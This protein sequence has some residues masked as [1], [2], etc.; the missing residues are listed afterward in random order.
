MDTEK[1]IRELR[2]VAIKPSAI[3]VLF[4]LSNDT[5]Y[6]VPFLSCR[7]KGDCGSNHT[8]IQRRY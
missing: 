5:K 4:P 6:N 3:R 1:M 8:S 2:A 7:S